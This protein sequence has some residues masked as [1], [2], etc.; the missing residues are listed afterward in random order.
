MSLLGEA[1]LAI[2]WA[3]SEVEAKQAINKQIICFFMHKNSY[4]RIKNRVKI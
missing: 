4:F 3:S 1:R 2:V